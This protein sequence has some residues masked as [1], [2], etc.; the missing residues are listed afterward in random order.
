M[1]FPNL[2]GAPNKCTPEEKSEIYKAFEKYVDDEEYPT[3]VSFCANHD[4]AIKYKL[5]SQNLKDWE[6]FSLLIKRANDKQADFTEEQVKKG[7]MNP[8]W[9]IFKLKQP[10]FGWTDKQQIEHANDPEHPLTNPAEKSSVETF[11]DYLKHD[12]ADKAKSD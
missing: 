5:I 12:T 6:Q 11:I 2:L 4:T 3:V 10:A 8:T 7:K 9:A 1:P